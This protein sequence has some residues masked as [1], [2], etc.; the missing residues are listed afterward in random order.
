MIALC[1]N[2]AESIA[3]VAI[4]TLFIPRNLS[5]Q[6]LV[7]LPLS[8]ELSLT[9]RKL[10]IKSLGDLN[11]V[12]LK[13][14]QRV[15]NRSSALVIELDE[16][17]QKLREDRPSPE[18]V[19][20]TATSSIVS[21]SS[22][23]PATLSESQLFK[24]E[25]YHADTIVIPQEERGRL[26]SSFS[27]SVRLMHIFQFKKFRLLGELHGLTYSE[28]AKYRNCGRRTVEELRGL[29]RSVQ[30]GGSPATT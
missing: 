25:L 6:R 11:G 30:R 22:I 10:G 2:D 16:L 18:S 21:A 8:R 17:I 27:V 4:Q 3:V 13:D 9:L 26:L 15:S 14:F 24:A 1:N 12:S 7:S 28:I 29:V 20:K 19:S 23:P 5:G